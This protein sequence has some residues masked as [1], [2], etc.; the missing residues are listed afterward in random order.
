MWPREA[1]GACRIDGGI[2]LQEL[3][4]ILLVC[5]LGGVYDRGD[6]KGK[7]SMAAAKKSITLLEVADCAG[8][9]VSTVSRVLNG[10]DVATK[11]TRDA[12][13]K[14]AIRMGYTRPRRSGSTNTIQPVID[15][16]ND[17]GPLANLLLLAPREMLWYLKS[18]DWI[19]RDMVPSL[20]R[21]AYDNGFQ[22][23]LASYSEDDQWN[24]I[25]AASDNVGGII[26]MPGV[27]DNRNADLLSHVAKLA[28]VVVINDD[29]SWPP[30][31]C[32]MANNRTVLFTAV[33]HL[34]ELG[35]RRIAYFDADQA[36][37]NVH[38]RERLAAY[39][40]AVT[41][42]GIADD[43]GL[44]VLEQFGNGQH[45]Q[46]VAKAMDRLQSGTAGATAIVAPLM[47]AIQFLKETRK[48]SIHVPTDMSVVAVDNAQAAELVDPPLTVIDCG[49]RQC[50]ALAVQLIIE[51][52]RLQQD[53]VQTVLLEPSLIVRGSTAA[54]PGAK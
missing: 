3:Y 49:F 51:Q 50:A 30:R 43:P 22:L 10:L 24:A 45:P 5:G 13:I 38:C 32:V 9:S 23:V 46:A 54:P 18:P 15:Q 16:S 47:Y 14:A 42:F 39:R 6:Q 37:I 28:P 20:Y 21:A 8:V 35:H 17:A 33:E 40:Q 36:H 2:D 29:S 41:H 44:C 25:K 11:E 19:F 31:T 12:V 34:V 26:W 1:A 48:R 4:Q 52:H 53:I 7:R 27:I